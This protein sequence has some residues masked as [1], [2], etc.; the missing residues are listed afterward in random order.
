ME[1]RDPLQATTAEI[2]AEGETGLTTRATATT[3]IEGTERE[4]HLV[5]A[6]AKVDPGPTEERDLTLQTPETSTT[7]RVST[8][9][10]PGETRR[11]P[12]E[13]AAEVKAGEDQRAG[14]TIEDELIAEVSP[15]DATIA[16]PKV[17]ILASPLTAEKTG[18]SVPRDPDQ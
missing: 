1:D 10:M 15:R 2:G 11:T 4:D 6:I 14:A 12:E 16:D 9:E 17:S 13:T 7:P 8:R 5:T 3:G 18:T